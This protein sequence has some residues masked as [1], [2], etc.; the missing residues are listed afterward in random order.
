MPVLVGPENP[1]APSGPWWD[2]RS[3]ERVATVA[4]GD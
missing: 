1:R 3:A 4:T 2:R